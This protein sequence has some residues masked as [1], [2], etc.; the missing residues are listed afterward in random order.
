MKKKMNINKMK[1][2]NIIFRIMT[3]KMMMILHLIHIAAILNNYNK[4]NNS[5]NKSQIL[6]NNFKIRNYLLNNSL[7]Q[8]EINSIIILIIMMSKIN[9]KL[10]SK[11]RYLS[12]AG[13]HQIKSLLFYYFLS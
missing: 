10:N 13:S 3:M 11:K 6:N 12:D 9:G 5:S 1:K 4:N 7:I 8:K 2:N